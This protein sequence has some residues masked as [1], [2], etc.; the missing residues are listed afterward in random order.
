MEHYTIIP[1]QTF[2]HV[3]TAV[4]RHDTWTLT[5]SFCPQ[6]WLLF[7]FIY[8]L[9]KILGQMLHSKYQQLTHHIALTLTTNI[10]WSF[11]IFFNSSF[12]IAN[13]QPISSFSGFIQTCSHLIKWSLLTINGFQSN[14]I[15]NCNDPLPHHS[16]IFLIDTIHI[17][18]LF[19]SIC[20]ILEFEIALDQE[21]FLQKQ[22]VLKSMLINKN[23]WTWLLF[24]CHLIVNQSEDML[25]IFELTY[26]LI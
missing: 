19:C 9:S 13:Q 3:L 14:V 12:I 1:S 23:V 20:M 21:I 16:L 5:F 25:Y 11:Q 26:I 8:Q 4:I 24:D 18:L 15:Y 10:Y 6:M 7:Y 2:G 22:V 17:K